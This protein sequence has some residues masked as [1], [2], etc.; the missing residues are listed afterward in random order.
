MATT[1]VTGVV[2]IYCVLGGKPLFLGTGEKA[3]RIS[4]RRSFSP[5]HN[6][7][8]GPVIQFDKLYAGKEAFVSVVL[9]RWEE[10]VLVAIQS[11]PFPGRD[12]GSDGP[13]DD[14]TLMMTEG[15]AYPIIVRYAN[16]DLK[17]GMRAAGL[18]PGRRFMC[19]T[20]D[21]EE[22]EEP[23]TDA[24]KKHL[25]WYCQRLYI[26]STGRKVLY[27]ANMMGTIPYPLV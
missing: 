27:D 4:T 14:G 17:P 12:P 16:F 22:V 3:P 20:L 18:A 11:G 13:G 21:G 26:P 9:T 1:Y 7:I 8:T 24:N 15:A 5:V 2:S 10:A 23:G 25:M 6:D 19:A